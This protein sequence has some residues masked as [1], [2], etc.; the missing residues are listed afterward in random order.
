MVEDQEN[1]YFYL[2]LL[3]ENYPMPGL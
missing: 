2:T 1:V 3:N